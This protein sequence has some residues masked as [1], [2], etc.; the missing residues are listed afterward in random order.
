MCSVW[1]C[2]M[3]HVA[4]HRG[5]ILWEEVAAA[6]PPSRLIYIDGEDDHG[7]DWVSEAGRQGAASRQRDD[8]RGA[9]APR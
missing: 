4:V 3:W 8:R 6:Y 1:C 9:A 7:W 2:V 5:L